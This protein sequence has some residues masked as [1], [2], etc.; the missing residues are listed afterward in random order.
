MAIAIHRIPRDELPENGV[1]AFQVNG[2]PYLVADVDGDVQAFLV[3]GPAAR[4]LDRAVIAEGRLRCPAHGWAID[5]FGRCGA[6]DHCR[7]EPIPVEVHGSE[8]EVTLLE[9]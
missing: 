1:L 6:A 5:R 3:A 8:I 4:E 9:P 7:Y 2:S